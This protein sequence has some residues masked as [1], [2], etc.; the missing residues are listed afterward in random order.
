MN[1]KIVECLKN[2]ET[3]VEVLMKIP[4]S[5]QHLGNI[6]AVVSV[7]LLEIKK[8]LLCLCVVGLSRL[9]KSVSVVA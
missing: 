2:I 3:H 9:S 8:C 4:P 1:E 7:A 6:Q 5:E